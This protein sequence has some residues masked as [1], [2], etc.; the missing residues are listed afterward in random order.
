MEKNKKDNNENKK[1]E[2]LEIEV[3]S[4]EDHKYI[5]NDIPDVISP[6]FITSGDIT[7]KQI[8]YMC[9]KMQNNCENCVLSRGNICGYALMVGNCSVDDLNDEIVSWFIDNPPKSYLMEFKEK[10][11]N[12]HLSELFKIPNMCVK[13]VFGDNL[14]DFYCECKSSKE[15]SSTCQ[16][17]ADCWR[18]EKKEELE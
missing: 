8:D 3:I 15:F 18:Q 13:D 14:K 2:K 10:F 12:A 9:N 5:K 11:P 1:E 7:L 4:P 16:K 6:M 17:C